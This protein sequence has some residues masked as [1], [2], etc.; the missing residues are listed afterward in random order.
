MSE[1]SRDE[2]TLLIKDTLKNTVR[3]SSTPAAQ[4]PLHRKKSA[5]IDTGT[6]RIGVEM[7]SVKDGASSFQ[8]PIFKHRL[9]QPPGKPGTGA[10]P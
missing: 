4:A 7:T 2:L 9:K 10:A 5:D 6:N 3:K 8:N 1:M